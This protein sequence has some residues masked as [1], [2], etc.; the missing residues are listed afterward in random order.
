M[1]PPKVS[2]NDSSSPSG[3]LSKWSVGV[4]LLNRSSRASH[5]LLALLLLATAGLLLALTAELTFYQD[6]WAILMHRQS[7]ALSSFMEPHNEHIVVLP[8]L[9]EKSLVTVFGMRSA[10]PELVLMVAMVILT[11]ALVYRFM[12]RRVSASI[13][14]AS[15]AILAFLGPGWPILLWPFQIAFLGSLSLG[16]CALLALERCGR[17]GDLLACAALGGALAFSSVGLSFISGAAIAL[18][19]RREKTWKQIWILLVPL[20]LFGA[21]YLGWG[22]A[23]ESHVSIRNALNAGP[24]VL[25]AL[26]SSA[27]VAVGLASTPI[28]APAPPAI[29][30]KAIVVAGLAAVVWRLQGGRPRP[31]SK[32]WITLA[33]LLSFWTLAALNYIPGREPSVDRYAF[34]GVV[35]LFLFLSDLFAGIRVSPAA[36]AVVVLIAGMAV[37]SNLVKLHDARQYLAEQTAL[38]RADTAAMEIARR[39]IPESFALTPEIAGT[40]SLI[41]INAPEYFRAIDSYGS[42]AY[43]AEELFNAPDAG[44][45]QADIVLA[46]ALPIGVSAATSNSGPNERECS[47]TASN[48]AKLPFGDLTIAI[49]PGP[50]VQLSLR[51]FAPRG[52]FPVKLEAAPGGSIVHLSIPEDF[53]TRHW[54]LGLGA[55]Q[56]VGIC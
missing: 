11:V 53:A 45:R 6:T 10:R 48:E 44:R 30:G 39:T 19:L 25:E 32:I 21:W 9:I 51:R 38:T 20:V 5:L 22:H 35:L 55:G 16:I 27:E 49:P 17:R 2:G 40:P 4:Q 15:A 8:T 29:W 52:V 43:S 14:I 56:A 7:W 41:D 33:I 1:A 12:I 23:A 24:Y 50:S 47:R 28:N 34:I 42:P 18:F 36:T 54:R 31:S 26:A 46:H 3:V 37:G 13:A